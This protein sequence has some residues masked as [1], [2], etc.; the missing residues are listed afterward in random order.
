VQTSIFDEDPDYGPNLLS[1]DGKAVVHHDAID[2][3]RA[4]ELFVVLASS[5]AWKVHTVF[6][7]GRWVEQPRL[8]AW[9]GNEDVPYR[10]SGSELRPHSWTPELVEL[11]ELCEQIADARFNSV[12]ANQYRHGNDSVAWHAD[13]EPELGVEPVIAS[14]S[15]GAERR[16]DLRHRATGETVQVPLRPGS[17]LVMSG[18]TQEHWVHQVAKTRRPVGS[19]INLTFRWI[20]A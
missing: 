20:H 2:P 12:L 10:Y 9:Y 17:V 11:R 13:N 14:V 7:F 15:L 1:R 19:R 3:R 6:V 16:F 18:R 5:L 8:T 4:S